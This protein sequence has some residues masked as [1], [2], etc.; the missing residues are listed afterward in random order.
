MERD[1]NNSGVSRNSILR[2]DPLMAGSTLTATHEW[3][4]TADLPTTGPNLGAEAVSWIP[5][6]FLTGNNF[7]DASK[8]HTY[9]LIE[10]PG[11]GTGLFFVGLETNGEIYA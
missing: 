8:N 9:D 5:D 6:S 11:H 7:F 3:N 10:Y 1:N 4:L 2:F